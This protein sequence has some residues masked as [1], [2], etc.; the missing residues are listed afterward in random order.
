MADE[1]VRKKEALHTF[2]S[3]QHEC[4]HI[5]GWCGFFYVCLYHGCQSWCLAAMC[6]LKPFSRTARTHA[7]FKS[8]WWRSTRHADLKTTYLLFKR[9]LRHWC[10]CFFKPVSQVAIHL[11]VQRKTTGSCLCLFCVTGR[12]TDRPVLLHILI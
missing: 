8:N 4:Q 9:R 7:D 5:T 6:L 10:N 11:L 3:G 12:N 2:L 1:F